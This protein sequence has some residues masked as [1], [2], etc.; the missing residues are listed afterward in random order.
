MGGKFFFLVS[1][2]SVECAG[3]G[4]EAVAACVPTWSV[5]IRMIKIN[6]LMINITK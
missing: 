3:T 5:M 4:V 2:F 1:S 6:T